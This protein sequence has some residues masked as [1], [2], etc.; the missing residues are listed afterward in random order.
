MRRNN[1]RHFRAIKK[2]NNNTMHAE[3]PTARDLNGRSSEVRRV[4]VNAQQDEQ[5]IQEGSR[6]ASTEVRTA[7]ADG[8]RYTCGSAKGHS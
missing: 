3:P 1:R 5:A 8:A 2:R 6:F 4:I 7:L